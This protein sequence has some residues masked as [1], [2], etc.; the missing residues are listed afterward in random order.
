MT[1]AVV[2]GLCGCGGGGGGSSNIP[3]TEGA[4]SP[5]AAVEIFLSSAGEAQQAKLAGDLPRA[6]D[7]YERMGAVFGTEDGSIFHSYANDEVMDR[8]IVLAACLR[9]IAY[10]II[11]RPDP[12]AWRRKETLVTAELSRDGVT[13]SLP[14]R[15]VLGPD[16]RWF[17]EQIHLE[18]GSFAC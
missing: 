12:D 9:P 3:M 15:T 5:E 8:M 18:T 17:V 1:A 7:G 2:L 11:S 14:F 6:R 13:L 16:D 4:S 10:R